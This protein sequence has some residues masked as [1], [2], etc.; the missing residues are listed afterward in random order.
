MNLNRRK[1]LA[2][3]T[4]GMAAL[5]I[6]GSLLAAEKKA[7]S[8]VAVIK[9]ER[10]VN[11]RNQA[12]KEECRQMV[13]AM[14]K[15]L[16][17][18]PDEAQ[19]WSSLGLVKTDVV[20]IKLNCNKAYFPVKTHPELVYAV[21]ESLATVIPEN[22]IIVYERYGRELEDAGYRLNT[23]AEGVRYMGTESN[24]FD[25]ETNLTKIVTETATKIIHIPTLKY[26]GGEFQASIFLKGHIGSLLPSV[27]AQC[28]GNAIMCTQVLARQQ[29]RQKNLLNICDGLR[30]TYDAKDP[31]YFKGI[32]AGTDPVAA[33]VAC[34]KIIEKKRVAE[35]K[36]AV[37]VM[38]F[39]KR[40]ETDYN[41]GTAD[42]AGIDVVEEVL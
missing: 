25:N 18:K 6:P 20:A 14:L 2:A 12:D 28:H 13:R 4:A 35:G 5:A 40:A 22:N 32:I 42:W 29:I 41:L 1:F 11:G 24:G 27:M 23:A 16:T 7:K 15:K 39:V 17:G 19:G 9:N 21:C 26:I 37:Q 36:S 3:G 10:C 31:W 33:E 34:L 38:D 8:K 30:G